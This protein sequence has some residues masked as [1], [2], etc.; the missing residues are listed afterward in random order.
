MYL[1]KSK[2]T[3]NLKWAPQ[4]QILYME[5]Y[6]FLKNVYVKNVISGGSF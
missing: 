2:M 1:P 6:E 4:N 3:L 5:N